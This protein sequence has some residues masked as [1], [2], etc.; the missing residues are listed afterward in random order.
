MR[1]YSMFLKANMHYKEKSFFLNWSSNLNY[2]ISNIHIA[3]CKITH[4]GSNLLESCLYN[5]DQKE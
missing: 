2:N 1:T 3:D 5:T 4:T